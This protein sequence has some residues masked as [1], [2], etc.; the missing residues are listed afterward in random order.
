MAM[1]L[2]MVIRSEAAR[3]SNLA[4]VTATRWETTTESEGAWLVDEERDALA[5]V[6]ESGVKGCGEV[7]LE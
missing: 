3:A 1:R 7:L 5:E 2:V 6:L 4:S